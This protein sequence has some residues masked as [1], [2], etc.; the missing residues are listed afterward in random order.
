MTMESGQLADVACP[1][2]SYCIAVGTYYDEAGS[3]DALAEVWD[4]SA[5]SLQDVPRSKRWGASLDDVSCTA[6]DFCVAVGYEDT[7]RDSLP[8]VLQWDG[9]SWMPMAT[10]TIRANVYLRGVSCSSEDHC[11]AVGTTGKRAV[12]EQWDGSSWKV[13]SV[14][15][16]A[17]SLTA[18]SC[19]QVDACMAVGDSRNGAV[20]AR[21]DGAGWVYAGV[22]GAADTYLQGVSCVATD[23]CVAVGV[24]DWD[25]I[26]VLTWN[27][28]IWTRA[29]V[30]EPSGYSELVDVTCVSP[31]WC[32]AVGYGGSPRGWIVETWDGEDWELA[33][34]RGQDTVSGVAC[35]SADACKAVGRRQHYPQGGTL[36]QSWNGSG[37]TADAGADVLVTYS[38]NLV[39]VSCVG[40]G[41]CAAAGLY[42]SEPLPLVQVR[43]G[44]DWEA[45]HPSGTFDDHGTPRESGV[46]TGISCVTVT[47]CVAVGHTRRS[48][49]AAIW[50]GT[51]WTRQ[52][53][54]RRAELFGVSCVEVDH[55]VAV[56][57]RGARAVLAVW[58]GSSWRTVNAPGRAILGDVS[59]TS[60]T[61]CLTIGHDWDEDGT[62]TQLW[63]GSKLSRVANPTDKNPDAELMGVSC[64]SRSWCAAVG[65]TP[66]K[67]LIHTW[68]G[69]SWRS[70]PTPRADITR[71]DDY[72]VGLWDVSC[73]KP[74]SCTAVGRTNFIG[75]RG[76]NLVEVGVG[77]RWKRVAVSPRQGVQELTGVSCTGNGACVAVGS[78]WYP[79]TAQI[80]SAR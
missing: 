43:D 3:Q 33:H 58:N 69:R 71:R 13:L 67:T 51:D 77:N 14:P 4:G 72:P 66:S 15:A 24:H 57:H 23:W 56:G 52:D 22:P 5:W 30:P 29:D 73:V 10:P 34:S 11:V 50:D 27:G 6:A 36:I 21:W 41:F 65:Y 7:A 40:S 47:A 38:A 68:D 46:L 70:S 9:S 59:C 55:C 37:W 78:N 12:A 80:L 2:P 17:S 45:T 60:R 64:A 44:G 19:L 54:L 53:V 25:T 32:R 35:A 76:D 63:N 20:A 79:S 74:R 75:N 26:R 18:V 1:A 61:F 8:V 62:L 28:T 48:G 16:G 49:I 39:D 31:S 42:G